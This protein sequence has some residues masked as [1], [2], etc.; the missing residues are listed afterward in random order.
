MGTPCFED[1]I[2]RR[3]RS[4]DTDGGEIETL[5]LCR[6]LAEAV[7]TETAVVQRA[8]RLAA[9][10]H[11]AISP[12]RRIERT[13][14]AGSRLAIVS[15]AV[16]GVRLSE[17]LSNAQRRYVP[18][19]VDAACFILAQI[20]TALAELH[21]YS[22]DLSHGA[23][24]PERI[25][26]G[27]DGRAVIVEPVLAPVLEGLQMARTPLWTEFRVP[28][29]PVAGTARFDQMTDVMQ[30]G[31]LALA[32]VLG[33]PVRRDE[34]PGRL[35]ELMLEASASSVPDDRQA[36]LRSLRAWIHRMLQ[37]EPRSAFR[38]ATEAAPALEAVLVEGPHHKMSPASV[39][40][41]IA[42]C[43]AEGDGGWQALSALATQP[44]ADVRSPGV[45]APAALA[46]VSARA[47]AGEAAR[48][49]PAAPSAP[50]T[51]TRRPMGTEP[52]S[53]TRLV[54]S[55]AG[56]SARLAE[57]L[58]RARA[59]R[60]RRV[61]IL[62]LVLVAVF[63]ATY[64]GARGYLGLPG[65]TVGRG[66]VVIES[67]PTGVEVFVDGRAS[68]RT[69]AT[70]DLEAGEHTVLLRSGRS[71]T[72]VPIV[73]VAGAH[74][75]ERVDIRPRQPARRAPAATPPPALPGPGVPQ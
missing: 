70:L 55:T 68:G 58:G 26:I 18:P 23:I 27:A 42:A 5:F 36:V 71:I 12:V 47:A 53:I 56:V 63:G 45:A 21:R 29:P 6:E 4:V 61:A 44:G 51:W 49:R 9:F 30:L 52:G 35:H 24:G 2:G 25:V 3:W 16:P 40:R 69:P 62:S 65:A 28:V 11:P 41:Y 59:R 66:I 14:G 50:Q 22:R 20:T 31:M 43:S 48:P 38:S 60:G 10:S 37:L 7:S 74:R 57:D 17:V 19:D 34:Y 67:H 54:G 33:R 32:L 72:L 8:A 75:V 64:L 13:T 39:A 46:S 73:V 15:A 1:G